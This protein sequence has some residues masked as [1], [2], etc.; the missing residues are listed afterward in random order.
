MTISDFII[1]DFIISQ[2]I[3]GVPLILVGWGEYKTYI[4]F[5]RPTKVERV[6]DNESY[7]VFSGPSKSAKLTVTTT[8]TGVVRENITVTLEEVTA[9]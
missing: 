8:G 5:V 7:A 2:P 1:A 6:S 9:S 3:K 4:P